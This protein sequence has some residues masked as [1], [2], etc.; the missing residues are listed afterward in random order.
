MISPQSGAP[1]YFE[2]DTGMASTQ[3]FGPR[4]PWTVILAMR[5]GT[6]EERN[7]L[8]GHLYEHYR[9]P[10]MHFIQARLGLPPEP[11]SDDADDLAQAFFLHFIENNLLDRLDPERGSFRAFM[12]KSL[13]HFVVDERRREARQR[14]DAVL[15]RLRQQ[16]ISEAGRLE[17]AV[18]N[19]PVVGVVD[20]TPLT[21]EEHFDRA[22]ALGELNRAIAAFRQECGDRKVPHYF[23]VFERLSLLP[24]DETP[25][26][27]EA[28]AAEMG[29]SIKD[30]ANYHHRARQKF[31]AVLLEIIAGHTLDEDAAREDLVRFRNL[32]N[33]E[34]TL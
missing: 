23:Q 1:P 11:I 25:P 29:K 16:S 33:K 4:T 27:H 20:R 5:P 6:P 2:K 19:R 13:V 28:L 18:G 30:I 32:F 26:S 9:N 15:T 8:L 10:V 3:S 31:K 12:K 21:P 22:W 34:G 7:A 17:E 14:P 24:A